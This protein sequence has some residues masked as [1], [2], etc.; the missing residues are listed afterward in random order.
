MTVTELDE[1][2]P[3]DVLRATCVFVSGAWLA[4]GSALALLSTATQL[5]TLP[6]LVAYGVFATVLGGTLYALEPDPRKP[7]YIQTVYGVGYR[8][9]GH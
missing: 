4:W 6:S 2:G 7:T 8:F 1:L 3:I 5:R 9:V